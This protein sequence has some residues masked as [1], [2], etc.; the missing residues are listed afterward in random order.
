VVLSQQGNIITHTPTYLSFTDSS[1]LKVY[2]MVEKLTQ[3]DRMDLSAGTIEDVMA[4]TDSCL[5]YRTN[6]DINK[7]ISVV[8]T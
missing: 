8:G 7:T 5:N 1:N 6:Q 4:E 3:Y 2:L